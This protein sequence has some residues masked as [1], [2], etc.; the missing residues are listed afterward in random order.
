MTVWVNGRVYCPVCQIVRQVIAVPDAEIRCGRCGGPTT[1]ASGDERGGKT[2][3][4]ST[5]ATARSQSSE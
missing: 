2:A 4:A 5:S 3:P 1:Q